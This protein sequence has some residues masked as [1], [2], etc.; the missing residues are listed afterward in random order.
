MRILRTGRRHVRAWRRSRPFWG[1]ACTVLAGVELLSIPFTS[2]AVFV[3]AHSAAAGIVYV[4]S[5]TM[6]L[7]GLVILL[8]P[9][10]RVFLGVTAVLLSA[11]SVVYANVGGFLVG[12]LLGLLGGA[13]TAAWT[14]GAGRRAPAPQAG[15]GPAGYGEAPG[16]ALGDGQH[17]A[18]AGVAGD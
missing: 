15:T 4:L 18:E 13:A 10:Q 11:A 2:H 12:A 6:I 3:A 5:I 7:L 8:Q 14:P 16:S 1:A 9:A 17:H